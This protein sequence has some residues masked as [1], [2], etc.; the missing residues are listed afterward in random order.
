M[1]IARLALLTAISIY[2]AAVLF[3]AIRV[4]GYNDGD[5]L[6]ILIAITLP[7]SLISVVFIWSLIHGASLGFFW[8]VYL[9]G[10]ALNAFLFYRYLPRLYARVRH[11]AA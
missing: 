1:R 5:W 3:S 7:W 11:R 6:L 8:F 4:L 10:G 9:G 2:G